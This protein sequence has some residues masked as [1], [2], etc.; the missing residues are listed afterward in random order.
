[1]KK[2]LARFARQ[3]PALVVAMIAL[4][5]ALTGTAVATTSALI[6]GSQIKN[7]SITGLDVRNRSLRPID[8]RGSVRG[9]RGLR[10]LTGA[11]GAT[12]AAG[13]KG[14]KGD[15]GDTGDPGRSALSNLQSGE[16]VRG[17]IIGTTT[18]QGGLQAVS[19][20]LP[21]PA[22]VALDNGHVSVNGI[23]ESAANECTGTYTNP[24]AAAGFACIYLNFQQNTSAEQGFVPFGEPTRF[25][26][27]L[28]WTVTAASPSFIEGSWAYTAP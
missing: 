8:F 25:G 6:T 19:A 23:D 11:T 14:D 18:G 9:P 26:L 5:V 2:L 27:G 24:T 10:G 16:T 17:V 20:S 15:K 12:G 1:L 22:P 28:A 7:N 21:I 4:F 3:S 13:A